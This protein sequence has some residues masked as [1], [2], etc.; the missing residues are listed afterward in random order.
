MY[1]VGGASGQ[2]SSFTPL[3]SM[4]AYDVGLESWNDA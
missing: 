3:S 4:E 2:G 1:V